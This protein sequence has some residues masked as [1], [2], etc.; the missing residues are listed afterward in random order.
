MTSRPT[1]SRLLYRTISQRV[2]LL[3]FASVIFAFCAARTQSAAPPP[4]PETPPASKSE[5]PSEIFSGQVVML[6][7]ALKKRGIKSKDEIK[8]QIVLETNSG[9]L[10]PIVP[11][12]RGRALYQDERL[13]NRPVDLVCKR[14]P[15]V[16]WLQ[17]LSIYT[18]DKEGTRQITDYWCD[19]CSIPMYEIKPC[20]CC[21]AEIRLRF[22]PQ[23]LPPDAHPHK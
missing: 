4:Q 2:S 16:P 23:K 7:A 11:D 10:W 1:T 9:E 6:Q 3:V 15:G 21:Q 13:R 14:T 17:V 12:W 8:D 19:I 20:D 5:N 22:R 18:F